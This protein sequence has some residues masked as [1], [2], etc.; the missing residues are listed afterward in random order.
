MAG[1]AFEFFEESVVGVL[2]IF[3]SPICVALAAAWFLFLFL[4]WS[5]NRNRRFFYE[6]LIFIVVSFYYI[7]YTLIYL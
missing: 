2:F 7:V 1:Y 5:R 3:A 6:L 4:R